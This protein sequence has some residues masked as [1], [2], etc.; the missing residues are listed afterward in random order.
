MGQSNV[1]RLACVGDR[2]EPITFQPLYLLQRA[3]GAAGA[4]KPNQAIRRAWRDAK[5]WRYWRNTPPIRLPQCWLF[6]RSPSLGRLGR[7]PV[8]SEN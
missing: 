7:K 8:P 6:C 2:L 4:S 3:R 5:L 1:G